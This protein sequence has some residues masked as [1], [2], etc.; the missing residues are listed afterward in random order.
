MEENL[1]KLA[2]YLTC[3]TGCGCPAKDRDPGSEESENRYSFMRMVG[4]IR[5]VS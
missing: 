4:E 2:I 3:R 5:E 1:Q